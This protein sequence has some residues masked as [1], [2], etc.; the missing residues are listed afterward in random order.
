MGFWVN[1]HK[2]T[3]DLVGYFAYLPVIMNNLELIKVSI[4]IP[5]VN[6][7]IVLRDNIILLPFGRN[8][9]DTADD[10]RQQDGPQDWRKG[11]RVSNRS[12]EIVFTLMFEAL[13]HLS[14]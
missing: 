11:D 2:C 5:Y 10:N 9:L 13:L 3:N 12:S 4:C 7:L 1:F 14:A 6:W 8:V